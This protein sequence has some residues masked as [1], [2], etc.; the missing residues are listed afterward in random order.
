MIVD[1][2][3]RDDR[4]DLHADLCVVGAGAAGITLAREFAGSNAKVIVLES[5]GAEFEPETQRLY[6]GENVGRPYDLE[7]TRLRFLGGTTNHWEGVCGPLDEI[8]F[9]ARPWV[10]DS[11][12]PLS[13][14]ELT[15]FYKR[16]QS[17]LGLGPFLYGDDV[18][19]HIGRDGIR[20]DPS[21]IR[22]GFRQMREF[23]VRFGDDYAEELENGKNIQLYLHANAVNLQLSADGR[24]I[25]NV[26]VRSLHGKS[27][28]VFARIFVLACGA[29]E[30]ARILLLSNAVERAGIG[31]RNDLVGRYFMEHP[32]FSIGEI[33]P[34]DQEGF[35]RRFQQEFVDGIR[36]VQHLGISDANQ[37]RDR[38]LNSLVWPDEVL[39]PDTGMAAAREIM[40]AIRS[41]DK[42]VNDLDEKIWRILVDLDDVV[43]NAY[44]RFILGKGTL[45]P[46][47]RIELQ[48]E[49]E[50]APNPESRVTL[51]PDKDALGLNRARLNWVLTDLERRTAAALGKTLAA[52]FG[53]LGL[54]R[55]KLDDEILGE[56][57]SP[58]AGFGFHQMG[59]T[60]MADDPVKG[61]VD[62]NCLIHGLSNTYVA[63]SSVFPTSGSKNPTLTIVALALRLSDHLKAKLT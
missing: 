39:K 60:R 53:R 17:V 62:R 25:D 59:T 38:I 12:W 19:N 44:R 46:I 7:T 55:G 26:D 41:K 22:Y 30:N 36:Y 9:H 14:D 45:P 56:G 3:Q 40:E 28:R 63:G 47:E 61:V 49:S 18:W 52:E 42:S 58:R 21:K 4:T 5:G 10:P 15:P 29:I 57:G 16:A 34:K 23:P 50:Q 1:F 8:D 35:R 13:R 54:G 2:N 27:G 32:L 48:V 20:F 51:L 6:A 11:G 24:R 37:G 43:V 31:N 33:F